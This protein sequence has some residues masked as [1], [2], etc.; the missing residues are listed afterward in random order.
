MMFVY[1]AKQDVGNASELLKSIGE[2]GVRL[3]EMVTDYRVDQFLTQGIA[4]VFKDMNLVYIVDFANKRLKPVDVTQ[5]PYPFVPLQ[6]KIVTDDDLIKYRAMSQ[7][8]LTLPEPRVILNP[9]MLTDDFMRDTTSKFFA[10]MEDWLGKCVDKYSGS[11]V[12]IAVVETD[13]ELAKSEGNP[14]MSIARFRGKAVG[15]FNLETSHEST[16]L[17]GY[18]YV[19]DEYAKYC[20][21]IDERATEATHHGNRNVSSD[22]EVTNE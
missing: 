17:R 6:S 4:L 15:V 2:E 7:F 14:M 22:A 21:D 1:T 20:G 13:W 12:S 9:D 8:K 16:M 11:D 3:A 18:L 10:A 19:P 5:K